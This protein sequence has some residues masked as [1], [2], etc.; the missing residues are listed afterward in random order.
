MLLTEFNVDNA[1][2]FHSELNPKLWDGTHLDAE[3]E[4]HLK[5]IAALFIQK[6]KVPHLDIVDVTI[7]GSNAGYTYTKYSDIDCHIVVDVPTKKQE[8]MR[9]LF[10]AKKSIFNETYNFSIHTIPVELYVQFKD[11][12]HASTGVYSLLREEWLR[13]PQ[14][15][16]VE[17]DDGLVQFKYKRFVRLTTNAIDKGNIKLANA[18]T[19]KLRKYR[20]HGLTKHG[21][22]GPENITFKLLRNNGIL[23]KLMDFK[24]ENIE[25][26]LSLEP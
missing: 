16:K 21:E 20:Q 6:L 8:L 7:S 4:A 12:P 11:E 10:D 9:N 5:A 23:E 19:E 2:Q 26:Q 3:V 1:I 14:P 17:I 24:R 15:I 13:K 22:L 25:S 18:I